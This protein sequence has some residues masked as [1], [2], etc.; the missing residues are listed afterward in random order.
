M[1]PPP[2]VAEAAARGEHPEKLRMEDLASL[3]EEHRQSR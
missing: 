1:T 2:F 3:R